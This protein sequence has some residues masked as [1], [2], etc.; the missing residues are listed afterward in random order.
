MNTVNCTHVG[1]TEKFE[2]NE[3]VSPTVTFTCRYHTSPDTRNKTRFQDTQFD[4]DMNRAG[5]PQGATHVTK[6]RGAKIK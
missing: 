2:T 6:R 1:C 4:K 3:P 5:F